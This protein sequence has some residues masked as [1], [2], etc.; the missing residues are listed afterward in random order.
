VWSRPNSSFRRRGAAVAAALALV[1]PALAGC[2]GSS[3]PGP[4]EQVAQR[5][6]AALGDSRV[7]AAAALT[8]DEVAAERQARADLAG[9]TGAAGDFELGRVRTSGDR[10]TAAYTASWA[11]PKATRRWT[12]RG[13]LP[14]ARIDGTW[15]VHWQQSTLFPQL[16][17]GEGLAVRHVQPDRAALLDSNGEALVKPT[18]VVRVGI[19]KKLVSDLPGLARTLAAIPQ[20]QSTPGEIVKA[21]SAAAPTEFV[22]VITLRRPAYEQ[23]KARIH[24]LPGTVF[25]ADELDLAPTADF[26]QPLLGSVGTADAAAAEQSHGTVEPGDTIGVGGLEHAFDRQ[27]A[28]TPAVVIDAVAADGGL[29]RLATLNPARAGAPVRLTLDRSVQTAAEAALA[30]VSKPAALVAVQRSTGR[31]LADANS[32]A[33]TY[34]YALSGAFPPGST[35]KIATWAAA[36]TADPTLSPASTVQCPATYDVDGRHFINENRFSH[37]PIS[38]AAAFA[39]SCNTTAMIE[40][41]KFSPSVLADTAHSLGLGAKWHLPVPAFSGSIPAPQ[42]ETERAA[43]AI[44]QGRVLA[45]PLAMALMAS[46]ASGDPVHAPTLTTGPTTRGTALPAA[47]T[48]KLRTLMRTTVSLPGATA[49][50]LADLGGVAGKTGTAEYGTAVPP[51]SHSWFVGTRG[52]LAFSVF[53]WDGATVGVN[54]NPIAHQ[55]LSSLP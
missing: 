38:V 19:E 44:G 21:V 49:H 1:I 53:V 36:F 18:A 23:I 9:L 33:T 34:D 52:D 30:D 16:R 22:P 24:D 3:G 8:T 35:F 55:F 2:H 43:D 47:L 25:Q 5:F 39:Y 11:V 54:A 40:A 37:P 26:A 12:Y 15:H 31:I 17:P 51:R 7:A 6:L 14:L 10:A 4:Q 28:G 29:R 48:A 42:T 45:S 13:S 32:A 20:L 46:A 27:L 41:L 50:T